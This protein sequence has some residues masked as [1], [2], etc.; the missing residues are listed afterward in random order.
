VPLQTAMFANQFS[1]DILLAAASPNG[2]AF[3]FG[4][5][6][7]YVRV[8]NLAEVPIRVNL[9]STAPA[10]TDDPLLLPG[11]DISIYD[12]PIGGGAV[13]TTSTTTSTDESGHWV[14]VS[15]WGI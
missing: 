5:N 8:I 12:V 1:T 7:T 15:A 11:K 2:S 6:S 4:F 10:T 13:M 14:S 9:K 3:V